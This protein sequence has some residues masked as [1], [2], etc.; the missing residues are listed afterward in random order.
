MTDF[1]ETVPQPRR[2]IVEGRRKIVRT[3][4]LSATPS[5]GGV[6]LSLHN[7]RGLTDDGSENGLFYTAPTLRTLAAAINE[8]A[9]VLEENK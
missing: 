9:D 1:I 2:R 4:V 3:R 6:R 8:I 5:P 7:E